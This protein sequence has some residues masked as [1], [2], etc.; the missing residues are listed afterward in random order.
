MLE[1]VAFGEP[2]G[3]PMLVK[4]TDGAA[5]ELAEERGLIKVTREA[6][7]TT[8]RLAHPLYGEVVRQRC[9]LT[10]VRRLQADLAQLIEATGARRHDD[11]LR[12][13]VGGWTAT[14]R[15]TR[16][17]C[18]GPAGRRT[19]A[20]TC[21]WRPAGSCRA[22]R[23]RRVRGGRGPRD[24]VVSHRPPRGGAEC[25]GR[26]GRTARRGRPVPRP[27][28]VP[29]GGRPYWGQ[30]QR[31]RTRDARG[32]AGGLRQ[33]PRAGLDPG[34]GVADAPASRRTRRGAAARRRGPRR[35]PRAPPERARGRSRE[36]TMAH[37]LA[38]SG[39]PAQ[40]HD[41]PGHPAHR[42]GPVAHRDAPTCASSPTWRAAPR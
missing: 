36:A 2:L 39:A 15:A 42:A 20:T 32:R 24:R 12:V 3:L 34:G 41:D 21:R 10:R 18:C 1:L 33:S 22:G 31:V 17:S 25:A 27:V 16:G 37:L 29:A 7:R 8:V 5:A 23:R 13:A 19:R 14:R 40:S 11:T 30:H 35:A 9:P 28:A 38:A 6:R 4:A 26:R